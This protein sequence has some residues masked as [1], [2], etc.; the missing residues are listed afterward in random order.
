MLKQKLYLGVA[1][2]NSSRNQSVSTSKTVHAVHFLHS[3]LEHY[4][5]NWTDFGLITM[6][7]KFRF[8]N[9]RWTTVLGR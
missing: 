3:T 1:G 2:M 8:L 6:H 5:E 4:Y 7:E 9:N